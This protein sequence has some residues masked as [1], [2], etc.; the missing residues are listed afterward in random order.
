MKRSGSGTLSEIAPELMGTIGAMRGSKSVF[1][2]FS[3]FRGLG[4]FRTSVVKNFVILVSFCKRPTAPQPFDPLRFVLI[5]VDWWLRIPTSLSDHAILTILF[6]TFLE[7][8]APLARLIV[9]WICYETDRE[10]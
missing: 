5:G 7:L 9:G 2:V 1:R 8:F 6:T 3:V 4:S 10:L